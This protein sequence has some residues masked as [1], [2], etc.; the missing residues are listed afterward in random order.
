MG[1]LLAIR[2]LSLLLVVLVSDSVLLA[3]EHGCLIADRL[4]DRETA[5]KEFAMRERIRKGDA[6]RQAASADRA[7]ERISETIVLSADES[8]VR[9]PH[10]FEQNVRHQLMLDER[11]NFSSLVV[12][13]IE[14]GVMLEG[15]LETEDDSTDVAN[16][17]RRIAG[18]DRVLNCLVVRQSR[19]LPRKG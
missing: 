11:L 19:A 17:V 1:T 12:R 6:T 14:N 18:V 4:P 9:H 2:P 8:R 5:E 15:V 10:W 3:I 16:L 13:R 7:D